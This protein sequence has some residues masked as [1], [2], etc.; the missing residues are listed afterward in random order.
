MRFVKLNRAYSDFVGELAPIGEQGM[1]VILSSPTQTMILRDH[2]IR[3]TPLAGG[4]GATFSG[5][6]EL[7][8]QG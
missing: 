3:L 1:S 2:R 6:V 5:E 8:V 7:D 4:A